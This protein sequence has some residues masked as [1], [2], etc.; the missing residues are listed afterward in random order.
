MK[1]V[2]DRA[3]VLKTKRPHL[4][5]ER[6]K[7]YKVLTE[8]KGVYKIAIP[9]GLHESQV[10][11]GLKVK[12]VPSPMARDYEYTGRYEPFDHQKET[13]SFLTLHKKGFCFNEQGTGKTASVIWAVDYLMQQGLINRVLVICPLSIMKS[14]WQEDLFKF[15]MHRT[16]SVAHGT[17]A[18]RKKIL[19]AGSEFVIINF[20]GVAVVK[21]EIMK[22][23]FDMIVVDEANAYKNAQTNR[24][25]TLRDITA[26]VP[27]LWML[28]GTP[29]AQS[30]VDA[31]G[32]AKLINPK[33]APKYFGQFRV[34]GFQ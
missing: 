13:A 19:N 16:C 1:I 9:W 12:E 32:L 7:N 31:F 11:A 6:V 20:D 21:D 3:I 24:W 2:N 33:G 27:W 18:Q 17:S 28:T 30:P 14:A 15:A 5:T 25:K 10:L 34:N 22:G 8:E 26:N 29:A 23:G 4:I